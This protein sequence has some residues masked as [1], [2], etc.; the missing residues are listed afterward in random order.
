MTKHGHT[1]TKFG[2]P[3]EVG[4]R[5]AARATGGSTQFYFPTPWPYKRP[6]NSWKRHRRTPWRAVR[7]A[8]LAE[9]LDAVELVAG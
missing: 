4:S 8:D 3:A 1:R 7:V 9:G 5:R 2:L 6:D